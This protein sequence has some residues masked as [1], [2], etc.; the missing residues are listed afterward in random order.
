MRTVLSVL[1]LGLVLSACAGNAYVKPTLTVPIAYKEGGNASSPATP[2]PGWGAAMPRDAQD[3]GAWWEI[4]GDTELNE[5]ES[6]VS[7]SNQTIQKAVATLQSARA[8]VGVAR[9][10]YFPTLTAGVS[11]QRLH[12]SQNVIGRPE[13][14]GKSVSDYSAGVDVSWEPDLFDKVGH[15]VDAAT[16]RAQAS[17]ADLASVQLSM[18]AELA[19]D[20]F[21]LHNS[22]AEIML[23]RKTVTAYQDALDLI[24]HRFEAGIASDFDLAQAQTQLKTTQAQL[25]DLNVAHAQLQHAIATLI[26]EPASNFSLSTDGSQ[27]APP[28]IPTG[29]PSQLLERR[30]DVAAAERRVAA[31]T[32]EVGQATAAFFPDLML[33]AS[34]GLESSNL[35]SW[36]SLPSR[37]WAIG[38]ALVGTVLDG[39]R[40]KHQVETAK[41]NRLATVADYRQVALTAF[42]EVEDN[43]AA[44]QTLA[45]EA[46][47]QYLAVRSSQHALDVALNRYQAG[48]VSYLDVTVAQSTALTNER[49]ATEIARR[50]SDASVLLIKALGGPWTAPNL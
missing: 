38:P 27:L 7:V 42:Q 31:S 41:D 34:G 11:Q 20:Y 4:F 19:I 43:L 36:L 12:T 40:R 33:S 32:A 44:V 29:V 46:Q 16:A 48:A 22:D 37:L 17:A 45:A 13:L 26:G 5:L 2:P 8:A 18:H 25:I 24:G 50:R 1:S 49:A 47:T 28:P 39:G 3:R 23:L 10:N 35:S 9:S 15:A 14:A 30:P 21:D 6:R